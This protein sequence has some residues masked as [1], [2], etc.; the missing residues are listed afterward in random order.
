MGHLVD[1][2]LLRVR[3]LM[4]C[5]AATPWIIHGTRVRLDCRLEHGHDGEHDGRMVEDES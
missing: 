2:N 3:C 5:L 1:V 4:R